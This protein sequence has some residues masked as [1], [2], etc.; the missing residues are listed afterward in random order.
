MVR[1]LWGAGCA[2]D[3]GPRA[4]VPYGCG[5]SGLRSVLRRRLRRLGRALLLVLVVPVAAADVG[6]AR[7]ADR[8]EVRLHVAL[9][10]GVPRLADLV[11][12]DADLT[13]DRVVDVVARRPLVLE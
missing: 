10:D 12:A 2:S 6:R 11:V 7:A 3:P 4:R 13:D 1:S 9:L 8:S 5:Q